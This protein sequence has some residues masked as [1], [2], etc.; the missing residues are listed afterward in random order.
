MH[1][2]RPFVRAAVTA[3]AGGVAANEMKK[4]VIEGS[5]HAEKMMRETKDLREFFHKGGTLAITGFGNRLCHTSL[6]PMIKQMLEQSLLYLE[7]V[8]FETNGGSDGKGKL[9]VFLRGEDTESA[10]YAMQHGRFPKWH[11]QY[12]DG[13]FFPQTIRH[14]DIPGST[15]GVISTSTSMMIAENFSTGSN[16]AV[17]KRDDDIVASILVTV[18]TS[19][20]WIADHIEIDRFY[21][22]ECITQGLPSNEILGIIHLKKNDGSN[23]ADESCSQVAEF[24]INPKFDLR[25]L[26]RIECDKQIEPAIN[27]LPEGPLKQKLLRCINPNLDMEAMFDARIRPRIG[28]TD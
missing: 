25:K 6:Y 16:T 18:P 7:N 23:P 14:N 5:P 17:P 15:A 13:F 19:I 8:R 21:E 27:S 28:N 26:D 9:H 24:V 20:A 12:S 22:R 1:S 11:N 3:T 2:M 4:C 10:K